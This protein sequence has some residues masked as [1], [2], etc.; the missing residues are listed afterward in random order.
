MRT[1][2]E[3][4]Q[5]LVIHPVADLNGFERRETREARRVWMRAP[6]I[7]TRTRPSAREA[8]LHLGERGSHTPSEIGAVSRFE[9]C[10]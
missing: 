3:P 4:D 2:T 1:D 5:Y 7:D 10:H 8:D 6:G 9:T